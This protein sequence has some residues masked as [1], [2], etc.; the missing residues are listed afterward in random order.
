MWQEKELPSGH[1]A[2]ENSYRLIKWA[3][4]VFHRMLLTPGAQTLLK[5]QELRHSENYV[6]ALREHEDC[7]EQLIA[8][9]STFGFLGVG[10][11]GRP[12]PSRG[13]NR[14]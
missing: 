14:R 12:S 3:N 9:W 1:D 6:Y 13:R 8:D 7:P 10:A 2:Y 5:T 11:H 4:V